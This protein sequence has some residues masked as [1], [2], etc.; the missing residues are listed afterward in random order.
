MPFST[1]E[2]LQRVGDVLLPDFV[3]EKKR[4]DEIDRWMRWDHDKPHSPRGATRE[5]KELAARSQTPWL[6]LVVTTVAQALYVDG[7][8]S[9]DATDNA[10]P[11]KIWQANGLDRRQ[12][13]THRAAIG[14]GYSFETV[15]PGRMPVTGEAMPVIRPASPRR[16]IAFYEDAAN[17]DWPLIALEVTVRR[18]GAGRVTGWNLKVYD[19]EKVVP[20]SVPDFSSKPVVDGEILLHNVG[21]CPVV[22]FTNRLDSDGR[23][24]GEVEPYVSIAARIDQT[25]FDR[26]VVQRFASWVVRTIAGM[27][28]PESGAEAASE[29][30][31]LMIEDILVAT[32]PDTKFGSLPATPLGGFIEA[33]Q[34]DIKALAAVSQTPAHEMTGQMANLSAEALAAARASATAK[35]DETATSFGESHEQKL[36]LAANIAGDGVSAADYSAQVRWRDTSIRSLAQAADALTKLKE[37]VPV[38]MLLEMIPTWTQQDVDTAKALIEKSGGPDAL[39][40]VIADNITAAPGP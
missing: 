20:F 25:T 27:A 14:Y 35:K 32:D 1:D 37:I 8:R 6:G 31:R 28:K 5:Y 3:V 7:Y 39:L 40:R 33:E 29:K 30:L 9:T 17:D 2:I 18:S 21:V 4:V 10:A 36:R 16:M 22:R 11:W 34:D 38:E 26:L 13:A 24:D 12:I 19:D 15:L 23:A